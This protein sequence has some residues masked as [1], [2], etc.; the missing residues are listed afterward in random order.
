[1]ENHQLSIVIFHVFLHFLCVYHFESTINWHVHPFPIVFP[2]VAIGLPTCSMVFPMFAVGFP[3]FSMV[4]SVFSPGLF[5]SQGARETSPG[6][7]GVSTPSISGASS[8]LLAASQPWPRLDNSL[9][10][11]DYNVCM[12]KYKYTCLYLYIYI[13]ICLCKY[14]YLNICRKK[15]KKYIYIYNYIYI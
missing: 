7:L 10:D 8:V 3:T 13:N 11:T 2:M 4:L 6:T 1:M 15:N 5:R 14:I 12:C 9:S